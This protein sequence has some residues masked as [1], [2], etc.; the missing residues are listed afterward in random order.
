MEKIYE[1]VLVHLCHSCPTPRLST[2]PA[3][4]RNGNY[5][6]YSQESSCGPMDSNDIICSLGNENCETLKEFRKASDELPF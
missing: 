3:I 2:I 1:S 4:L 6:L 5:D